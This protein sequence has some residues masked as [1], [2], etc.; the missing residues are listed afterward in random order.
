MP[1][2]RSS[3]RPDPASRRLLALAAFAMAPGL[4]LASVTEDVLRFSGVAHAE[5]GS[6]AYV[7]EHEVHFDEGRPRWSMTEYRRPDGEPFANLESEY[8]VLPY[9]PAYHFRDERFGR[10]AGI[11]LEGED[12]TGFGRRNADADMAAWPIT[13]DASLVA[14]Q[15]L[16]YYLRDHLEELA[17]G[18]SARTVEFFMPL[19]GQTVRFRVERLEVRA[20]AP[21][22][23]HFDGGAGELVAE[24]PNPGPRGNLR[25]GDAADHPL[26]GAFQHSGRR[27]SKPGCGYC[28]SISGG[29]HH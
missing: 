20:A 5:D 10:E 1:T 13:P 27:T 3:S 22:G 8:G 26:S 6:I 17:A 7:E 19:R 21:R 29:Q 23:T 18:D 4:A 2:S 11:V 9:L 12:A 15:G 16:N 28:L 25:R 24:D 14:G